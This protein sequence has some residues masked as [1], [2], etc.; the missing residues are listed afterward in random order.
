MIKEYHFYISDDRA[1]DTHFLQHCIEIFFY[2]SLKSRNVKFN[3]HWIWLDGCAG[4]FKYSRSFF[5]N[6]FETGHGKGEH[7][8]AGACIKIALR[9]W[10]MNHSSRQFHSAAEIVQRCK[11]HLSHG[12]S[13]QAKYVHRYVHDFFNLY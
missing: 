1:H 5:C 3:E 9:R 2:D 10:K 6:F 11:S 7:D 8:G 4:Q 12:C 13:Q